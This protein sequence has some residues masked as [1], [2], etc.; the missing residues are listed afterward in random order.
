MT[1][2][3]FTRSIAVAGMTLLT[4]LACS[5]GDDGGDVADAAAD[6]MAD[7]GGASEET[8]GDMKKMVGDQ[9][10]SAMDMAKGAFVDPNAVDA[11]KLASLP[12]MTAERAEALV[13]ARPLTA[14]KMNEILADVPEETRRALYGMMFVPIELN[15]ASDEDI[16][17]I[18]GVGPRMLHE[19][20]EYRPYGSMAEFRRE[21]GKY[22]DDDELTRLERYVT[23][24]G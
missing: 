21:I 12:G 8:A 9:M 3:A 1:L 10:D 5:Q 24:E 23:L 13:A 22:V 11:S 16:L 17:A 7:A 2:R 14:G 6:A 20:K 15:S 19:F 4:T 18:P